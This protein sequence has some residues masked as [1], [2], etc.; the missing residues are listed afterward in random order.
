MTT[1]HTEQNGFDGLIVGRGLPFTITLHLKSGS[2]FQAGVST[3]RFIAETRLLPRE[4]SGTKAT[5]SLTDPASKTGW[6]AFA[7]TPSGNV[8]SVAVSSPPDV[9]IGLYF[10]TL[11]QGQKVKL[12]EFVLLFNPWCTSK[13]HYF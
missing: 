13:S 3:F 11:D 6:S 5:F 7:T 1:H 8:I 2:Q 4:E 10:L 12:W 9:P